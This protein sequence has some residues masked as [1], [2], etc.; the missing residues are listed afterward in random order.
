MTG[1]PPKR[2]S[3]WVRHAGVGVDFAAA[4]AVFTLIGYWIDRHWQLGHKATIT[5]AVLGL[6]GGMYNL[7]R[8]SLAAFKEIDRQEDDRDGKPKS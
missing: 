6:V 7:V 3:V 8:A 2:V 5:G 1:K 4:V